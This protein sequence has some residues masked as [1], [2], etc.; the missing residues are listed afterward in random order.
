MDGEGDELWKTRGKALNTKNVGIKPLNSAV[1]L[2]VL[3]A[4]CKIAFLKLIP[5]SF[6]YRM[7]KAF[8]KG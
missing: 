7:L 4:I 5:E 3:T 2:T 8:F 6:L 1:L